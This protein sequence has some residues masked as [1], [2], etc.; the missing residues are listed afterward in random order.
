MTTW[1]QPLAQLPNY[2]ADNAITLALRLAYAENAL[3]ALT[4]DQVDAIVGPKGETY[5][6]RPAQEHLRQNESRLQALIGSIAD[7]ITVVNRRGTILSQSMAVTRVLGYGPEE[8]LGKSIFEF[9]HGEDVAQVYS[10]FFNVIEGILEDATV[11]FRH[12]TSDGS[13]RILEATIGKLS[14][15]TA[16][17]AVLSLRPVTAPERSEAARQPSVADASELTT[18]GPAAHKDGVHS[19]MR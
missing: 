13:F 2:G 11:Q 18:K 9:I 8:L 17:S 1:R 7:V 16:K 14:D 12:R 4:S 5:L 10:A 19:V 15:P 3:H 6:L